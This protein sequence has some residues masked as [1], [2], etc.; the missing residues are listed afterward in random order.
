MPKTIYINTTDLTREK[1]YTYLTDDVV[2]AGSTIRVQSIIGFENPNT[3][4]GQ[5][6][7]IGNVGNE[8]TEIL[9]TS[10]TAYPS[11]SYKDITL[12]DT[13]IFDHPQDTQ[14]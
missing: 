3:S 12:R 4:S 10:Q 5:I 7:V 8:R 9:R 2:A 11:Q 14:V 13:L 6:L 1:R